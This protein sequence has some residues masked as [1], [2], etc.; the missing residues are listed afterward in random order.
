MDQN[1]TPMEKRV[2]LSLLYDFYGELLKENQKQIFED[3]ALNDYSLTE[4]A[5]EHGVSRQG[6]HDTVKRCTRQL[7]DYEEKLHLI[8]RFQQAGEIVQQIQSLTEGEDP[9]EALQE[10]RKLSEHIADLL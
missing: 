8:A 1:M 9:K 5:D 4:I 7:E 2:E 6:I 10:I 3:Y